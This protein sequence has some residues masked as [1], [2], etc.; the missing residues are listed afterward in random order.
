M[1]ELK[2]CPF[3]DAKDTDDLLIII[4]DE[5]NPFASLFMVHCRRCLADGPNSVEENYAIDMW[6]NGMKRIGVSNNSDKGE[7]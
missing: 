7:A 2:P 5:S 1:T 6:N 4:E 3:C